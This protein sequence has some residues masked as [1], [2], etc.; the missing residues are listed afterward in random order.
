MLAR[1]DKI[2]KPILLDDCEVWV[3]R[4]LKLWLLIAMLNYYL[5]KPGT[6]PVVLYICSLLSYE[7]AIHCLASVKIILDGFYL[8]Y[9]WYHRYHQY[10]KMSVWGGA[11]FQN[12][13]A[14]QKISTAWSSG[15]YC[16]ASML[17]IQ[18]LLKCLPK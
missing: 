5:E 4:T 15:Q 10:E 16:F 3:W 14:K 11:S 6:F 17:K 8:S 1:H 18:F 12:C 13:Q 7:A 2:V 9:A